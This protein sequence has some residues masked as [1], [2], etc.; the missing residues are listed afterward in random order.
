MRDSARL[1]QLVHRG[2]VNAGLDIDAIYRRLGYDMR[3]ISLG[4]QRPRHELQSYFWRTVESV[5]GDCEIGLHLCPYLPVYRAG[6]LEYLFLSCPTFGDGLQAAFKYRRL[7]S[8]CLQVRVVNDAAG[9]RI[10]LTGTVNNAPELRHPEILFVH[11]LIRLMHTVTEQQ[12][13][14]THINLCCEPRVAEAEY[15]QTLDCPVG[16][17]SAESEVWLDPA[18]L[19]IPSPHYDP[20]MFELHRKHAHTRLE[21][22]KQQDIVDQVDEH[23]RT[24]VN[25]DHPVDPEQFTLGG[26]AKALGLSTRHLRRQL[27][28]TGTGFRVILKDA[29][30]SFVRKLLRSCDK[31]M[32]E[33][34]LAAG[35]SEPS[36]FYRAFKEWA[37]VTPSEY[38]QRHQQARQR[39]GRI[40]E[41][42]FGHDAENGH[43]KG[44]VSDGDESASEQYRATD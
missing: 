26:V 6:V 23:L 43:S 35:F 3:I 39:A 42:N 16:F 41:P 12:V 31:G 17:G 24:L 32:D 25:A 33:I 7:I 20:N 40:V 11:E 4:D 29:R 14:P 2:M 34:G 1:L 30:F 38:R 22:I 13:W 8:D 15:A 27:T 28:E 37:G 19:D 36:A 9:T 18:T 21:Q 44:N 10:A 5:T